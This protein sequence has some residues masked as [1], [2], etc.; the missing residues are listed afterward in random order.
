MQSK[1]LCR[2]LSVLLILITICVS[3][4][5]YT[6]ASDT[7]SAAKKAYQPILESELKDLQATK[8]SS[9]GDTF[10]NSHN[11][12]YRYCDINKDGI[13]ELVVIRSYNNSNTIND[14]S[15]QVNMA[16]YTYYNGKVHT[17]I[18]EFPMGGNSYTAAYSIS[19]KTISTCTEEYDGDTLKLITKI[20]KIV[21]G[22]LL[23]YKTLTIDYGLDGINEFNNKAIYFINKTKVSKSKYEK[24]SSPHLDG[25]NCTYTRYK[26]TKKQTTLTVAHHEVYSDKTI[27]NRI[28]TIRNYYNNQPK[29]LTKKTSNFTYWCDDAYNTFKFT[30]YLY[31]NDLLFAYGN[32]GKTEYRLYFYNNQL[33]QM[34]IDKPNSNRKTHTQLYSKLESTYYDEDLVFYMDME[35]QARK[36]IESTMTKTKKILLNTEVI[37]TKVSGSTITYHE[38]YY[39]GADGCLWTMDTQPYTATLSPNVEVLGC[40]DYVDVFETRS[41][42]WVED[43]TKGFLGLSCSLESQN[44]KVS[45]IVQSYWP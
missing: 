23:L 11:L 36:V 14:S 26:T 10:I 12:Y 15:N 43:C 38:L 16:I 7:N 44:G 22:K 45:K 5:V 6:N 31:G 19:Q 30:Y 20:Y 4:P 41:K 13:Y 40:G 21:K 17:L 34:L 33:I 18:Q 24:T 3:I 29:K 37:I 28:K 32:Q 39:Y 35:S 25:E 42:K 2:I 1:I 9:K 8:D 27:K